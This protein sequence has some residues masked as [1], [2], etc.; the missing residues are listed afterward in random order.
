[1][2]FIEGLDRKHF[3]RVRLLN[4]K[5]NFKMKKY[6]IRW[7]QHILTIDQELR[8]VVRY[9]KQNSRQNKGYLPVV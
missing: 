8:P 3:N 5:E 4:L 2:K 9:K 1:M 6:C 7:M